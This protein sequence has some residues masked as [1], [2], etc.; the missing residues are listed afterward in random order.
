M[1]I[2]CYNK[3][4][5]YKNI[6]LNNLNS[7]TILKSQKLLLRFNDSITKSSY[8]IYGIVTK[9]YNYKKKIELFK[10]NKL[11]IGNIYILKKSENIYKSL[12][13]TDWKEIIQRIMNVI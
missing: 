11:G 4:N 7:F 10:E 8:F 6:F 13:I 12:F 1:N 3:N 2:V 5:E 9:R